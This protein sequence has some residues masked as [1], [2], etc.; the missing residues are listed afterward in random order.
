MTAQKLHTATPPLR[1][2]SHFVHECCTM[3]A[4]LLLTDAGAGTAAS[5]R[6]GSALK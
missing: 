1:W 4:T 5:A 6:C 3:H 2:D